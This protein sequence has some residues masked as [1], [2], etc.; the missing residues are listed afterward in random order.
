MIPYI[1]DSG[2]KDSIRIKLGARRD[3]MVV[4]DPAPVNGLP[5]RDG[6]LAGNEFGTAL[7]DEHIRRRRQPWHKRDQKGGQLRLHPRPAPR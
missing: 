5:K 1:P 2:V 6:N 3:T 4:P 7:S